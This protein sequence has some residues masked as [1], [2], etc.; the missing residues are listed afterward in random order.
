MWERFRD[1]VGVIGAMTGIGPIAEKLGQALARLG[2]DRKPVAFTVALIALSAKMA[3]ADGVVSA[4]EV[5]TFRR[6]VDVPPEEERNVERLFDIAKAD[7]AGFETYAKRIAE[8]AEG[9]AV[10]LADV[11]EGLFHI[12]AADAYVHERE[13]VFLER[14]AEIFG[15]DE[16]AFNRIAAGFIRRKGP[17][18]YVVI[19]IDREATDAEVKKAY[20]ARVAECHPDRHF[21]SGLPKEALGMLSD[22]LA[23]LNAAWESVRLERGI[24]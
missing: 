15:L 1:I 23:A 22:R 5:Q 4:D 19:G 13:L 21:A 16:A 12:A 3:V 20:R 17:D 14:V 8:I 7:V 10:F 9:D 2:A 18:P 24:S 6:V 11:L